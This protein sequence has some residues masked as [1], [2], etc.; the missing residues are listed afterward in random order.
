VHG[1]T[2]RRRD[3]RFDRIDTGMRWA[4]PHRGQKLLGRRGVTRNQEFDAPVR[5]VL[6]PTGKTQRIGSLAHEPAKSD[7]LD[8]SGD[9]DVVHGHHGM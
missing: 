7:A 1:G 8:A 4:S 6:H 9:A 3:Y 5:A 2:D